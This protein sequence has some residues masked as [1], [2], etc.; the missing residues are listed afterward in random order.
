MV[1]RRASLAFVVAALGLLAIATPA[2]AQPYPNKLIRII[3][4][5]PPGGPT[6]GAARLDR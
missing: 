2:F 5:F 1:T 4:P 6:D 3:A